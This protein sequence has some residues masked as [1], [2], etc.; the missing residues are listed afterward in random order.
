MRLR[1]LSAR[2]L[3][4]S[5]VLLPVFLGLTGLGLE[6]AFREAMQASE[7]EQLKVQSYLLLPRNRQKASDQP[8]IAFCRTPISDHIEL[9]PT[10][11]AKR[12]IPL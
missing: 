4:A 8:G 2:L 1:S 6:R 5:A 11:Q 12:L 7:L 9:N 10:G 3:L